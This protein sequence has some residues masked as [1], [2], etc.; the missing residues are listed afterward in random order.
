MGQHL[1]EITKLDVAMDTTVQSSGA[2]DANGEHRLDEVASLSPAGW[3]LHLVD[4]PVEH[5]RSIELGPVGEVLLWKIGC[6][7]RKK[8]LHRIGVEGGADLFMHDGFHQLGLCQVSGSNT[9]ILATPRN[10]LAVMEFSLRRRS[11]L[12]FTV[13]GAVKKRLRLISMG[14]HLEHRV[15][16]SVLKL[17]PVSRNTHSSLEPGR[18]QLAPLPK[19]EICLRE[20]SLALLIAILRRLA[21]ENSMSNSASSRVILNLQ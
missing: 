2:N 13:S 8:L 19:G 7:A 16:L 17:W 4:V 15:S 1:D 5:V 20:R 10:A 9:S 6:A 3:Q 21:R 18:R 11:S 14:M 12:A